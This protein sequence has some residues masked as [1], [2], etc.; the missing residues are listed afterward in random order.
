MHVVYNGYAGLRKHTEPGQSEQS[1]TADRVVARSLLHTLIKSELS[2][3]S[4][5]ESFHMTNTATTN[6][7]QK[8]SQLPDRE[9][10]K[11]EAADV[12]KEVKQ[13]AKEK[14]EAGRTTTVEQA[15][16][17]AGVVDQAAAG[18]KDQE[19][20]S[21]GH[22]TGELANSIRGFAD[23]LR[24]RSID[25]LVVDAQSLA[26]R[27]P[28]LFLLGSVAIGVAIS[29]FIKASAE[30]Q[31]GSYQHDAAPRPVTPAGSSTP[32]ES[33]EIPADPNYRGHIGS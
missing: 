24:D 28:T 6:D 13:H 9:T 32:S 20:Q 29:R 11:S 27:N 8:S 33:E 4:G 19:Q 21:L 5:K 18:F 16:K 3:I 30:R 31:K 10:L 15:E 1:N 14:L 22:Y 2:S 12:A 7:N 25:D 23:K 17:L 26:R